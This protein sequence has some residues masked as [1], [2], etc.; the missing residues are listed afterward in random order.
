MTD[1]KG[2]VNLPQTDFPMKANLAA[3]EPEQIERWAEQGIYQRI[4][5]VSAHRGKSFVLHDGPPYANGPLHLGHVVNKVLKDIVVKS[6]TMDGFDPP[7]IP[8]WDCHGLPIELAVEKKYGKPGQKL[9]AAAFRAACRAFANSQIDLQRIGFKRLGIFGDWERPYLTMAPGYEA[10]QIRALG[11]IIRNGHLYRGAK[12][13]HWCLDC[14]SALAEAEV[15]YEDRTSTAIDVAFRVVAVSDF[16]RRT[17]IDPS[18]L[19]DAVSIVIWTTTPWRLPGERAG[20]PRD[21]FPYVAV[22]VERDGRPEVLV[23]AADLADACLARYLLGAPEL[24]GSFP[25]RA[26]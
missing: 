18:R 2:T 9:D 15:E 4:R 24:L 8:G 6:H 22:A 19:G 1:Y 5:E 3:H 16:A 20:P 26:L 7:Y 11:K 10:Q 25:G 12:P 13:V 21:E 14:R 17:R 23:L